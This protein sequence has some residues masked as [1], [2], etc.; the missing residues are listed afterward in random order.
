M[1]LAF[2][3]VDPARDSLEGEPGTGNKLFH[4]RYRKLYRKPGETAHETEEQN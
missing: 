2:L 3:T 4:F 1:V